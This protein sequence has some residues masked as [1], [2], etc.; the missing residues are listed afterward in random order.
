MADCRRSDW[1]CGIAPFWTYIVAAVIL[2]G[3]LWL[4]LRA[5]AGQGF[6]GRF[7]MIGLTAL[8]LLFNV[9]NLFQ[10]PASA[11]TSTA[12]LAIPGLAIYVIFAVLAFWLDSKRKPQTRST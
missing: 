8:M 9:Y 3:G 7:G 4:Y 1:G 6:L 2:I 11:D 10:P 5:T 12:M